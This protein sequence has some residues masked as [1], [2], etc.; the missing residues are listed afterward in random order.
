MSRRKEI[1]W[2]KENKTIIKEEKKIFIKK[3]N[4]KN[5]IFNISFI[6]II[7]LDSFVKIFP[8]DKLLLIE[9][10]YSSITLKIKGI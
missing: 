7:I 10:T 1:K 4:I 2:K 6:L 8:G 3:T 9:N 5:R